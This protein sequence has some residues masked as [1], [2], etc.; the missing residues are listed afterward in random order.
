MPE[1]ANPPRNGEGDRAAKPGG[2]G[3]A[4]GGPSAGWWKGHPHPAPRRLD[5]HAHPHIPLR[6]ARRQECHRRGRRRGHEPAERLQ[7]SPQRRRPPVRDRLGQGPGAC[8]RAPPRRSDGRGHRQTSPPPAAP[9]RPAPH[10]ADR[11]RARRAKRLGRDA[12]AALS[13]PCPVMPAEA[14]RR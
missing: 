8:P 1:Q 7:V 6:A 5:A 2:G 9:D 13:A 11:E 10:G 4:E 12:M 3:A 14:H